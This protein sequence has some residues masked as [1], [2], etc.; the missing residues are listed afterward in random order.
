MLFYTSPIQTHT[1]SS[2]S[3]LQKIIRLNDNQRDRE[4]FFAFVKLRTFRK[5]K[6]KEKVEL[7]F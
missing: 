6:L 7:T 2:T 5:I 1:D 4:I 3:A